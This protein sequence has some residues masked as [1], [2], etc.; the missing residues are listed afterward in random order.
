[1]HALSAG[2]TLE[3]AQKLSCRPGIRGKPKADLLFLYRAAGQFA[4]DTVDFA[5]VVAA[6]RKFAL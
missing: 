5:N 4:E 2:L 6:R 3:R 1:M